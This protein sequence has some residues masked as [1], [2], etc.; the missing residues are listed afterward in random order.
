MTTIKDVAKACGVSTATVSY[1][2]NGKRVLLPETRARVLRA[3]QE[4]NYH[5]SAVARGLS[6]KRMN[7]IGILFGTVNTMV[8]V[9]HPYTSFILQGVL[10]ASSSAGYNVTFCTDPW[11]TA[12]LSAATY[13]DQRTDGL[14]VVAP[15]MDADIV[16]AL[17]SCN[18][19]IV[20]VSYPGDPY[21]IAS[22]DTDNLHGTRL[23][24]EHLRSLGH[25]RIAHLTGP[26][27]MLGGRTRTEAYHHFMSAEGFHLPP[28]YAAGPGA[29]DADLAYAQTR[30]LLTLPSPPTAIF[31]ANDQNAMGAMQA[32]RDLGISVPIRL[33]VVGVDDTPEGAIGIPALTSVRQP[34]I[35][36]GQTAARLLFQ[37]LAGDA[38]DPST[39]LLKPTL[40]VRDSTAPPVS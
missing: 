2:L 10:T 36:I 18:I 33:S 38:P 30:R 27:N 23:A 3:M 14:I 17:A 1:V 28:E 31:A 11:R 25:T 32:A 19:P 22:V 4:L 7:T 37:R 13:R 8:V 24:L 34:L 5:P 26:V 40:V 6:H 29:F 15:P 21:G 35:E 20:T 16:P 39:W 12:E 9:S